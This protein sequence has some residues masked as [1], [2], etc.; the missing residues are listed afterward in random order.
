MAHPKRAC[1]QN[2]YARVF[3]PVVRALHG[4]W[5][6]AGVLDYLYELAK[7]AEDAEALPE[8]VLFPGDFYKG[9][10]TSNQA[11]KGALRTLAERG[12]IVARRREKD[13]ASSTHPR[14]W[15]VRVNTAKVRRFYADAS[16]GGRGGDV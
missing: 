6:A 2:S 9:V 7:S 11:C 15:Y 16:R 5:P 8:F 14:E 10:G 12:L 4:N 13:G 3:L 1:A